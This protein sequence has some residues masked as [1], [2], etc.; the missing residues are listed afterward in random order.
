MES[1]A[2][3][4][5]IFHLLI[6]STH[7]IVPTNFQRSILL[8]ISTDKMIIE[9]IENWA[10]DR[11]SWHCVLTRM[12]MMCTIYQQVCRKWC[13]RRPYLSKD[14]YS[15]SILLHHNLAMKTTFIAVNVCILITA[16][17][18]SFRG[19][20]AVV[21]LNG[22]AIPDVMRILRGKII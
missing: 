17:A 15:S 5:T 6:R 11:H 10:D 21:N 12:V 19:A 20:T 3:P 4:S 2:T 13:H 7:R 22:T 16:T 9:R 18:G 8:V 1:I 14:D